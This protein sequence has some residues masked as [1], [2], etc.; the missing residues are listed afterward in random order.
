MSVG[1]THVRPC[2]CC[3]HRLLESKPPRGWPSRSPWALLMWHPNSPNMRNITRHNSHLY[4]IAELLKFHQN[5]KSRPDLTGR[6]LPQ[7]R[8]RPTR[9]RIKFRCISFH[10]S[11]IIRQA[12]HII[13][14]FTTEHS[15]QLNNNHSETKDE[16][17]N[18]ADGTMRWRCEIPTVL[19]TICR[20]CQVAPVFEVR[21]VP[22]LFWHNCQ[23]VRS[24][25]V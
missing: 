2:C 12:A 17:G 8:H 24:W 5:W 11:E 10:F 3:S 1:N 15:S 23:V 4:Q 16:R 19:S 21:I 9:R 7:T 13:N 22:A 18:C 14:I 6:N 20:G 25:S